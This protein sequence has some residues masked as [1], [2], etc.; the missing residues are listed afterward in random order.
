MNRVELLDGTKPDDATLDARHAAN[1]NDSGE[2][3]EEAVARLKAAGEYDP[4]SVRDTAS[5]MVRG[6]RSAGFA[7]RVIEVIDAEGQA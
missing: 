5:R 4:E 3:A 7:A 2:T 1:L 6:G